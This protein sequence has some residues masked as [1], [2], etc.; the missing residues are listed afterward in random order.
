MEPI[1]SLTRVVAEDGPESPLVDQ[2]HAA[3]TEDR[4][5]G[6]VEFYGLWR[7]PLRRSLALAI[8][9]VAIADEAV[10]EAMT[11]AAMLWEKI[12]TYDKPEGWVYRVALNWARGVFRRRRYEIVGNLDPDRHSAETVFPDLDVVEAVGRLPWRF[13]TVVVARYYLDWSTRQVANSLNV[14][15]GTVKS[16][17]SRALSRLARELGDPL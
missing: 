14:P 13:R 17:L 1:S 11:R 6:F 10:D 3:V 8:G 2:Q 15:E 4:S 16:R 7:D 5:D 9:D 12:R